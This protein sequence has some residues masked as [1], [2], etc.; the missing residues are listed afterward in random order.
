MLTSL[1]RNSSARDLLRS[2]G[3]SGSE[4]NRRH[5]RVDPSDDLVSRL[6]LVS[7]DSSVRVRTTGFQAPNFAR[8]ASVFLELSTTFLR[9]SQMEAISP[10]PPPT[11]YARLRGSSQGV[12]ADDSVVNREFALICHV[13]PSKEEQ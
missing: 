13:F 8:L 7:E 10:E 3:H 9:P 12:V 5:R 4:R 11:P 2:T 6:R 1:S